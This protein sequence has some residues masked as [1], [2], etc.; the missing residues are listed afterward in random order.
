MIIQRNEDNGYGLKPNFKSQSFGASVETNKYGFRKC[1]IPY[2]KGKSNWLLLGDSVLMGVG[3]DK[4]STFAGRM[5]SEYINWNI[6]NSGV[7]GFSSEDY[8]NQLNYVL[9][10]LNIQKVS[11]FF[12]LN[13]IYVRNSK[14]AINVPGENMRK[15]FGGPISFLRKNSVLYLAMKNKVFDR[16]KSYFIFDNNLYLE[17]ETLLKRLANNL[18]EIQSILN[19]KKIPFEIYLLPYEFQLRDNDVS[20]NRPQRKLTDLIGQHSIKTKDLFEYMSNKSNENNK[21]LFLYGD[22][23]HLSNKGHNIVFNFIKLKS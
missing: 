14:I 18:I 1:S 16:S 8:I 10:F 2:K 21:R 7:I 23:M 4:D 20:I 19:K 9:K 6:I 11:L 5:A 15:I 17:N 3:V 12:C 13:D 22:P